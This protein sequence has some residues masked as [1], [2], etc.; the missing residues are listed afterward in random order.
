MADMAQIQN[1][2]STACSKYKE[3]QQIMQQ[4]TDAV[5]MYQSQI[6]QAKRE[7]NS[8]QS[9]MSSNA[10]EIQSL[11][12]E[13]SNS[14]Q[15]EGGGNSYV[16]QKLE[17]LYQKQQAL[18]L[19]E[20]QVSSSLTQAQASYY[21]AQSQYTQAEGDLNNTR[22]YLETYRTQMIQAADEAQMK[23]DGFNQSL[24]ILSGASGNMFVSAANSQLSNLQTSRN[25]YQEYL[26]FA[27]NTIEQISSTIDDQGSARVRTLNRSGRET[28]SY[29]TR[30]EHEMTT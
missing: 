9:E 2:I 11:Q 3:D 27:Q 12:Y 25:Q 18:S 24:Q 15:E 5:S 1:A 19:K 29:E 21:Q 8:I 30:F 26:T 6:S 7:L 23:V 4:A 28:G 22:N 14:S 20:N 13:I 16:Y 10:S 17:L